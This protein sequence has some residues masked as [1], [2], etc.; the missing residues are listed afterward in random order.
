MSEYFDEKRS[1]RKNIILFL[2]GAF[3]FIGC[4][5]V[6]TDLNDYLK[7]PGLEY[8]RYAGLVGIILQII[9][10]IR[11]I[12]FNKYFIASLIFII[13]DTLLV[14][15]YLTL[16]ILRDYTPVNVPNVTLLLEILNLLMIV[17]ESLLMVFFALGVNAIA[18]ENYNSM[19]VLTKVVVFVYLFVGIGQALLTTLGL[20]GVTLP[21]IF[22]LRLIVK[23]IN[24]LGLAKE[25]LM[26]I[27][28][29]TA[30]V[31]IKE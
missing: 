19:N 7:I 30:L 21:D 31:R 4:L 16:L 28:L 5:Y 15:T 3:I 26:L 13:F 20:A 29:I 14:T 2:V 6:A 10:V 24:V 25:V 27:F 12:Q 18:A 1:P 23:A 8:A 22:F 17:A 11:L 9:A